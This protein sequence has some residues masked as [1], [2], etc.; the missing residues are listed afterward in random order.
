MCIRDRWG[1]KARLTLE[2]I[3][4]NDVSNAAHPYL[5]TKL[6]QI[7]GAC[8]LYTSD[9]CRRIERSPSRGRG[10]V[11]K[12]QV[13]TKGEIDAGEDYEERCFEC[14]APILN[15]EVDPDQRG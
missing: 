6:I 2:K 7:N 14:G 15:D 8:L 12:R 5:T 3:T 4:K 13:G 10:D 1:P 11:Y 9:A